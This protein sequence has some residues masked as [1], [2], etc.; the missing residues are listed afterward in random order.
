MKI[1]ITGGSGFIGSNIANLLSDKH[2]IQILDLKKNL[3]NNFEFFET[4]V[5]D[6]DSILTG[7]KNCDVVIHLAASLGVINTEKN[8]TSTLDINIIGTRNVLEACKIN[9]VKKII[10]SSSSEVYGEPEKIPISEID[11]V[12]PITSY[13]VSKLASEEYVKSYHKEHNFDYTIFRLFNV[14]GRGQGP[15]WVIP[16]FIKKSLSGD[17]LTIHGNGSQIRAFC[18]ID[19]IVKAFSLALEKGNNDI[20][21]IG[22]NSEPISIK[23]L[24]EKI[25][26]YSNSQSKINFIPF[27]DSNRNRTEIMTRSPN[28]EKAKKLLGYE[29]TVSFENGLQSTIEYYRENP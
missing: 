11:K 5:S 28:T 14:Y 25:I 23:Q 19:D 29:P 20:F 9:N 7:T 1:A 2:D 27:S 17:N 13:G 18:H 15:D 24:A 6:L 4:N 21:N 10:L 26:Q 8:P 12:R 16:E 22:N 3:K